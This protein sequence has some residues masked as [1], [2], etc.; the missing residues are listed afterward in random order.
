MEASW[1]KACGQAGL[2]EDC[3]HSLTPIVLL[4]KEK[5][6]VS[7]SQIGVVLSEACVCLVYLGPRFSKSFLV[8]VRRKNKDKNAQMTH[9]T[10]VST[11]YIFG[12][13]KQAKC[14]CLQKPLQ[15]L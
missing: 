6:V 15:T 8:T 12:P 11:H 4:R 10:P 5:L 14:I 7:N 9:S 3:Q 13:S 2:R 1:Q